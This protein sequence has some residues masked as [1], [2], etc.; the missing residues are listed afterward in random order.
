MVERGSAPY[1][2]LTYLVDSNVPLST[3]VYEQ[4]QRYHHIRRM[5]ML[6]LGHALMSCAEFRALSISQQQKIVLELERGCLNYT[7]EQADQMGEYKSWEDPH[8]PSGTSFALLY[9]YRAKELVDNL[10]WRSEVG[11]PKLAKLL[12]QGELDPYILSRSLVKRFCPERYAA[13]EQELRRRYEVQFDKRGTVMYECPSCGARDSCPEN[14]IKRSLDEGVDIQTTCN[15][16]G[17]AWWVG[18]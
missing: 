13:L 4:P 9:R 11:N 14:K 10:D 17:T 16:C 3:V 1:G 6:F 18:G 2:S 15:I 12:A 7:V 5:R 8:A